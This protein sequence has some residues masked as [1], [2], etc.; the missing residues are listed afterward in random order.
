MEALIALVAIAV[1]CVVNRRSLAAHFRYAWSA[2]RVAGG[3]FVVLAA[4]F[5]AFQYLGPT[6]CRTCTR[7]TPT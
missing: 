7:P 5:L 2:L 3:L 1:L 6:T 4:P